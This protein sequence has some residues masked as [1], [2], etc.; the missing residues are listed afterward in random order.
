MAHLIYYRQEYELF[1]EEHE[2]NLNFKL[3]GK[4]KDVK[5]ALC[6]EKGKFK[7]LERA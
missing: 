4:H 1:K 2:K 5:C 7:D 6:H 3:T